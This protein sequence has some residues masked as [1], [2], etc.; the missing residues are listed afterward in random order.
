[1]DLVGLGQL[2]RLT[3]GGVSRA[4]FKATVGQLRNFE[5]GR[6][7]DCWQALAFAPFV[8]DAER[9][10]LTLVHLSAQLEPVLSQITP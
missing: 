1:V 8:A 9:Q 3:H 10:G 2:M 6:C 7:N 4:G 5:S